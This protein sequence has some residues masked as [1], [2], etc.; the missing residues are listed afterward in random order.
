MSWRGEIPRVTPLAAAEDHSC[1]RKYLEDFKPRKFFSELRHRR[2]MG[3][4]P[5]A[6][7]D[8][9]EKGWGLFDPPKKRRK[10]STTASCKPVAEWM[11]E[12]NQTDDDVLVINNTIRDSDLFGPLN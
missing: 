11:V 7:R 4:L 2:P 3:P 8:A 12:D 5:Y 1:K 10:T 6:D 9:D